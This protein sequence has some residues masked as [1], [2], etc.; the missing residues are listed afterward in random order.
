MS[1]LPPSV[2][3]CELIGSSNKRY[4]HQL[5]VPVIKHLKKALN[6]ELYNDK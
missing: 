2:K 1:L 3:S 6:T 4:L 5:Y